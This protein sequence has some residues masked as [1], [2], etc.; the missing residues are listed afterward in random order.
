MCAPNHFVHKTDCNKETLMQ[1]HMSRTVRAST[2]RTTS[3]CER[4]E[5]RRLLAFTALI[6]FQPP[7][8]PTQSGYQKDTGAV[9]GSRGN[10]LTYGWN[11]TNNNGID[12]NSKK[13]S[14][15]AFDTFLHM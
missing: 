13:S 9:F 8:V 5:D 4:L 2:R 12:R 3:L 10:G 15:Q 1:A 14:N 6:D 7:N 11:A